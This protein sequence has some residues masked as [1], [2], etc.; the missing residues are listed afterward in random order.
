M[1][2]CRI[3]KS[4]LSDNVTLS[5][6]SH[7]NAL[8][9]GDV[10]RAKSDSLETVEAILRSSPGVSLPPFMELMM[11]PSFCVVSSPREDG[12]ACGNSNLVGLGI[13]PTQTKILNHQSI[14]ICIILA[15]I[16]VAVAVV[17]VAM[18]L[19]LK[20]EKWAVS[21]KK[22]SRLTSN[23]ECGITICFFCLSP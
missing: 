19:P 6:A 7:S 11:F 9:W 10:G 5:C 1:Y 2:R 13:K 17:V 16:L 15:T 21:K 14:G 20:R 4:W 22:T 8:V 12:R 23:P 18:T 3:R